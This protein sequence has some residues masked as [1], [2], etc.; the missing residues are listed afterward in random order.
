MGRH[1]AVECRQVT[2][3]RYERRQADR[4]MQRVRQEGSKI[5]MKET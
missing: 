2:A 1:R 5:D 4:Q 3:E